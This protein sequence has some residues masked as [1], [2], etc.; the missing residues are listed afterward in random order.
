MFAYK[1]RAVDVQQVGRDLGV[2]YGS[3]V[4]VWPIRA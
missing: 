1:G 3:P 4:R 2:R